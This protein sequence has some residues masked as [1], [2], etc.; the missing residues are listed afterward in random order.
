ML[1]FL[2]RLGLFQDIY[3]GTTLCDMCCEFGPPDITLLGPPPKPPGVAFDLECSGSSK[4]LMTFMSLLG[5]LSML[6]NRDNAK[7]FPD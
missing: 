7:K 4:Y 3:E 1:S 5:C 6:F 2:C